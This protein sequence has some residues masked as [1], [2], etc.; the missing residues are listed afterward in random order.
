[1]VLAALALVFVFQNTGKGQVSFLLWD[2]EA[3][4]WLWMLVL[5]LAGV[6]VG[7]LLPRIRARRQD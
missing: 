6:A 5:F 1:L 7:L 4:A 3:A 2:I